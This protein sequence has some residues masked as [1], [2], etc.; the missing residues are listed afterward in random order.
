M[1]PMLFAIAGIG[2]DLQISTPSDRRRRRHNEC[3]VVDL[4]YAMNSMNEV[5]VT[6]RPY[7]RSSN[8][9][10]RLSRS[11]RP[12]TTMDPLRQ[13]WSDPTSVAATLI[14]DGGEMDERMRISFLSKDTHFDFIQELLRGSMSY[15]ILSDMK[16]VW[17][18]KLPPYLS[19]IHRSIIERY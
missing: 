6:L 14:V 12:T 4:A 3:A 19:A 17:K 11:F 9:L 2:A 8:Q 16:E 18:R 13:H 10:D 15:F 5:L 7:Q 1:S